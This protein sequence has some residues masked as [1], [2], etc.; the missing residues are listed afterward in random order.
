MG[1][2]QSQYEALGVDAR[3]GGFGRIMTSVAAEEFP[4]AFCKIYID[5]VTGLAVSQHG[6][7]VGSKSE[8]D[9][10]VFLAGAA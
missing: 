9:P 6:D 5:P 3:K 2:R 10:K 1:E 7:G 4:H 8:T